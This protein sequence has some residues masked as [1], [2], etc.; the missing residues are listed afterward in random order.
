LR[1]DEAVQA[2]DGQ[3]GP[4]LTGTQVIRPRVVR[5]RAGEITT[6]S[7]PGDA[8]RSTARALAQLH[9]SAVR[10]TEAMPRTGAQEAKR[11][12][13]R[14]KVIAARYPAQA[15]AVLRL[16]HQLAARLERLSPDEYRPAHG[17]FKASQ[18]LFPG[19][20]VVMVDFDAFCLADPALDVG[21]FLAYLRPS[22]LW[23]HRRG[24]RDW[25][26]R[27]ATEFVGAYRAAMLERGIAHAEIERILDHV[28]L[29]EAAIL[30]KVAI[31]R[32][33]RLNSPRPQ[34]LSAMLGEML[35][36]WQRRRGGTNG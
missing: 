14:A 7:I 3:A 16:A 18:L 24:L 15:E 20:H 28:R 36:A 26:E 31:R 27:A 12:C 6:A 32:S 22:G 29:Y 9:T 21:Y 10:P 5:T 11:A 23:Y 30:F 13:K 19:P 8:L 35:P 17:G 4:V 2:A 25:F 33:N 34:E 1:L